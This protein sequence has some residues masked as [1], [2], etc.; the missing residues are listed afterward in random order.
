M[1]SSSAT[2]G[3]QRE[4]GALTRVAK[5]VSDNCES[6]A[7]NL[8]LSRDSHNTRLVVYISINVSWYF[9]YFSS[10]ISRKFIWATF[11]WILL[12]ITPTNVFLE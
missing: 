7:M 6:F 10:F 11:V 12:V 8:E 3:F 5:M 4:F 9:P 2:Y 1:D